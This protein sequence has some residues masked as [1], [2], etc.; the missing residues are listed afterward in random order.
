MNTQEI[1]GLLFLLFALLFC[2]LIF[3]IVVFTQRSLPPPESPFLLEARVDLEQQLQGCP[4]FS[5]LIPWDVNYLYRFIPHDLPLT[6]WCGEITREVAAKTKAR[7]TMVHSIYEFKLSPRSPGTKASAPFTFQ[8]PPFQHLLVLLGETISWK[9]HEDHY[10]SN[11][12]VWPPGKSTRL[13]IATETC[14]VIVVRPVMA[15]DFLV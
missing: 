3:E 12:T 5:S 15:W 1:R 10:L 6:G 2:F 4:C 14:I 11:C 8:G 9:N 13:H 7:F